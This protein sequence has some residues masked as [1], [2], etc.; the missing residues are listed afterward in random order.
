MTA[1]LIKHFCELNPE[2]IKPLISGSK[3]RQGVAGKSPANNDVDKQQEWNV[4]KG[5]VDTTNRVEPTTAIPVGDRKVGFPNGTV[6]ESPKREAGKIPIILGP[7]G[8]RFLAK[9]TGEIYDDSNAQVTI[10]FVKLA[11]NQDDPVIY[12]QP[13]NRIVINTARPSAEIILG[14]NPNNPAGR[15]MVL[16]LLTMAVIDM[17]PSITAVVTRMEKNVRSIAR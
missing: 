2:M 1:N 16:P 11:T 3:S 17:F 15:A 14:G 13:P 4:T 5:V 6:D 12:Y 7:N 10:K 9:S 8:Q